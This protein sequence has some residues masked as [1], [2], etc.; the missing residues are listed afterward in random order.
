MKLD[1]ELIKHCTSLTRLSYLDG[2]MTRMT[3]VDTEVWGL[4]ADNFPEKLIP[5]NSR[6]FLCYMGIAKEKLKASYGHVHLLTFGHENLLDSD[7]N[8]IDGILGHM[9]DVYCEFIQTEIEDG[10]EVYLYPAQIDNESLVYW[11]E[12]AYTKWGIKDRPGLRSF[13]KHNELKG[14]IDWRAL[15][16][17]LPRVYHPSEAE[18]SSESESE[19]ESVTD[20][21]SDTEDSELTDYEPSIEDEESSRKRRKYTLES[22]DEA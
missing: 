3:G 5:A 10:D 19:S 15:E 11:S 22:E 7:V 8:T 17:Y 21:E 16:Q 13:I 14:W 6:N 20:A 1:V 4:R 12:I 2:L 18:Y 9:Y